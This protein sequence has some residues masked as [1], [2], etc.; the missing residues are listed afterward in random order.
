M[1]KAHSIFTSGNWHRGRIGDSF[2]Y[3]VSSEDIT[4][5][6]DLAGR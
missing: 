6:V 3:S 1:D 5:V 4:L 2:K